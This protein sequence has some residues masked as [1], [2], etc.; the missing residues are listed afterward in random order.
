MPTA[1]ATVPSK[2]IFNE[3]ISL[4]LDSKLHFVSCNPIQGWQIFNT[5]KYAD[6]LLDESCKLVEMSR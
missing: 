3:Q 4:T 6:E 2:A 1:A 5:V